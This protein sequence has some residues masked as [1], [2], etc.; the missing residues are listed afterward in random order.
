MRKAKNPIRNQKGQFLIEGLLLLIILMGVFVMF[1][2]WVQETK[3]MSKL[4]SGPWDKLA[5]MTE[6]GVWEEPEASRKKHPNTYRR[7]YTP[8]N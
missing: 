4:I 1:S 7:F 3:Q 2:Q 8:E 6:N 5:G